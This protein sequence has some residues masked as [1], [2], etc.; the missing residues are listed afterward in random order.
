MLRSARRVRPYPGFAVTA[1]GDDTFLELHERILADHG[2]QQFI[3]IG[4]EAEEYGK[5]SVSASEASSM[6]GYK[7]QYADRGVINISNIIHFRYNLSYAGDEVFQRVIGCFQDGDLAKLSV[8]LN[9][10]IEGI[11]YRPRVSGTSI[12]RT[13]IELTVHILHIASNA[14]VDVDSVLKGRDP[15][16]WIMEQQETPVITD[17]FM[18]L[19]SELLEE[20]RVNQESQ[21]KMLIQNVCDQIDGKLGDPQLGLQLLSDSVG[22]SPPYLS[23]L[24]KADKGLGISSYITKLR[25]ERAREMLRETDLPIEDIALQLGYARANYFAMV[26]K[27]ETGDTPS[28]Y[29][30]NGRMT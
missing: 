25:V 20:M 12:K 30:R 11:R 29:R 1:R 10:L 28:A 27:K 22:L 3:G 17:W 7:F 4:S 5:I 13:M 2:I 8:K 6:L 19:A 16:N 18:N 23:Q 9:E 14:N 24:F 26:F 15:Y 21:K